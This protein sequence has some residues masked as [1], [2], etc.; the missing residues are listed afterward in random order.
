M[1]H[2]CSRTRQG[3]SA[4]LVHRN[5]APQN[6]Q[7]VSIRGAFS[8]T[9]EPANSALQAWSHSYADYILSGG[10]LTLHVG[11]SRVCLNDA[12]LGGFPLK[13]CCSWGWHSFDK[14][15]EI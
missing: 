9:S 1:T 12:Y 2:T 15:R 5:G 8:L 14:A 10:G 3:P 13:M 7:Q 11:F 6:E 4:S